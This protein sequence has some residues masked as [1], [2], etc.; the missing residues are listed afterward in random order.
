MPPTIDI[1]GEL[2]TPRKI[3]YT[4]F[5]VQTALK[6]EPLL[7]ISR[8]EQFTPP[9]DMRIKQEPSSTD[10]KKTVPSGIEPKQF[11]REKPEPIITNRLPVQ[12]AT[13]QRPPT[14]TMVQVNRRPRKPMGEK[15]PNRAQ[16]RSV[17]REREMRRRDEEDK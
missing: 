17:S 4:G 16:T 14:P 15:D 12:M 8:R 1:K 2:L 13:A 9:H 3:A 11:K 6:T 5:G 10:W 7:E